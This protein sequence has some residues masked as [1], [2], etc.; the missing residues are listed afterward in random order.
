M[1]PSRSRL[2]RWN[3]DS[4]KFTGQVIEDCGKAVE[5]AVTTLSTNIKTMQ[6]TRAWSGDAH[7]AATVMFGRASDQT[8]DFSAY[9]TALGEALAAG[10]DTIGGARTARWTRPIRST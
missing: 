1:L 4:L 6:E 9:T 10:A 5:D 3:P 7:T 2:E 8:K